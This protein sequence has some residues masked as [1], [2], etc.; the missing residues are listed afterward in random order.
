[1]WEIQS[2]LV[3]KKYGITHVL[4]ICREMLEVDLRHLLQPVSE[5]DASRR[6][7]LPSADI[8][9]QT[10]WDLPYPR[11]LVIDVEDDEKADIAAFFDTTFDFIDWAISYGGRVYVH[12][13]LGISRGPTVVAA[14]CA[15]P[16]SEFL[17]RF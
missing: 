3:R 5:L 4:S 13:A 6:N 12:C 15:C 10:G 17:A 2:G 7:E 8:N 16:H 14:Y 11:H 1:M 9:G